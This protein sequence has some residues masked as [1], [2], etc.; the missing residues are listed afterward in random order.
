MA[1]LFETG[2]IDIVLTVVRKV[3][4]QVVIGLVQIIVKSN[5]YFE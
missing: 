5:V 1:L 2:T 3:A 4:E